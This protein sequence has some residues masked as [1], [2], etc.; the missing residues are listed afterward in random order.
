M[1]AKKLAGE[2]AAEAIRD[3]MIVGL[4]TGSTAYFT[5][6]KVGERV[7]QGLNIRAVATSVQTEKMARELGISIVPFSEVQAID[8]TIDGADE[9]DPQFNLIKGGG[10]ALMREK[11]IAFNSKQYIIVV[12]E[13]KMVQQM[14]TFPLPVEILPFGH[15]LTIRQLQKI[16]SEVT[17]RKKDVE[18]FT[19]DN[20]N[21][22][23]DLHLSSIDDTKQLDMRLRQVPGVLE[24]GLF[25]HGM[26][27]QVM[28]GT[29][30]GEVKILQR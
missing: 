11:L 5:I 2:K 8:L 12:D 6:Q 17:L 25:V 23:A 9:V 24:T 29:S 18:N 13:S 15:E 4:G 19:T 30:G 7:K 20:G 26:V 10:G 16:C 1:N 22:I 28:I 21:L 14:G 27:N 3:N